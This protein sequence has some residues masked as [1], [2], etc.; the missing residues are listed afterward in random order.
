MGVTAGA[1]SGQSRRPVLLALI[2]EHDPR[3]GRVK[4]VA[5]L[6][7][8]GPSLLVTAV[9]VAAGGIAVGGLPSPGLSL[10]LVLIMLPAQFAFGAANDP[11]D[12]GAGAAA[13]PYKPIV[14]RPGAGRLAAG[15]AARGPPPPRGPPGLP[16]AAA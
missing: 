10:R 12:A 8:P 14:R 15:V 6:L 7:H 2:D 11:A 9:T 16:G 13:K 1:P 4:A 5:M 3:G